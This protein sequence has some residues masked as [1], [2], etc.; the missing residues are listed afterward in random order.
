MLYDQNVIQSNELSTSLLTY[1][2]PLRVRRGSSSAPRIV[3]ILNTY[4]LFVHFL[5]SRE[6]ERGCLT[7]NHP[8]QHPWSHYNDHPNGLLTQKFF[9][10]F[11]SIQKWC[12]FNSFKLASEIPIY[13][14]NWFA[15]L[16][17]LNSSNSLRW[18]H[19]SL[20]GLIWFLSKLLSLAVNWVVSLQTF[21]FRPLHFI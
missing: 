19:G 13:S 14:T 1:N 7:Y 16:R 9:F 11:I 2:R 12:A 4:A 6:A 20:C 3:N 8:D 15:N 10:G 18:T 17:L 21:Q 5:S